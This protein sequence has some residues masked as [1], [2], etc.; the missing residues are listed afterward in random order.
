MA[1]DI[2]GL[3]A[4]YAVRRLT[5]A[6]LP[7]LLELAGRL[8][9]F[10]PVRS[11]QTGLELSGGP[12]GLDT[13]AAT[14]SESVDTIFDVCEPYLLQLGFLNRTPRGR[15]ATAEAYR[16]LGYPLP[17]NK[18]FAGSLFDNAVVNGDLSEG[19]E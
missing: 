3:S 18:S 14:I 7:E 17:Q 13:L 5:E 1:M 12:V 11:I 15:L 2:Q 10:S 8:W 19:N 9:Q 16:Y 6:D 4:R